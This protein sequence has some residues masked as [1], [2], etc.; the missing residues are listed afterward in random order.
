M[1]NADQSRD[2]HLLVATLRYHGR[3]QHGRQR[4]RRVFEQLRV[5]PEDALSLLLIL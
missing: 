4:E 1:Y 5:G 3:T 2:T